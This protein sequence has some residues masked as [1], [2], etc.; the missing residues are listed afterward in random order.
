MSHRLISRNP[1]LKQLRDEGYEI[2]ITGGYVVVHVPYVDS[3]P[4]VQQ[5]ALAFPYTEAGG[6]VDKPRDH[7]CFWVGKPP[8]QRDGAVMLGIKAGDSHSEIRPGMVA[9]MQLSTKPR[10]EPGAT[11]TEPNFYVKFKRY[12]QIITPAAE[13]LD[14]TVKAASH[15]AVA[16]TD[17][18]S[19]FQYTDT[20][21]SRAGINA[22]AAKFKPLT[23]SIIGLG[24][25]GSYILDLIAKTAVQEIRLFD[26]D[27]FST[28]NAFRAPGAA[29][30][31]DLD[32]RQS[33]VAYFAAMYSK[34]Y[35]HVKPHEVR[36]DASN[37]QLLD[38]TS[39][40]FVC[41]DHGDARRAI[42]EQLQQRAIPFAD[43]GMGVQ[44]L[45]AEN[46]LF[47]TVRVTT[48]S[49]AKSDHLLNGRRVSL[50]PPK[51]DDAYKQNIQIADLNAL[52]AV[53]AVLRWK[54]LFG[55]Y[56]DAEHEHHS[57]YTVALN[58][59]T[60]YEHPDGA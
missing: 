1:D 8:C 54:K 26:D 16:T 17:D 29:S 44:Y 36:I 20:A 7:T 51:E 23:I 13:S 43:V 3:A 53:L 24:G 31:E 59:L 10:V 47:G 38:G 2:E 9:T 33:K 34:I 40:A 22:I 12:I 45:A 30:I 50:A 11:Y 58:L 15:R 32:K 37:A 5:G 6:I 19:P 57:T 21:S 28:H 27:G 56:R 35:K 14:A 49:S 55:I 60:S 52:N 39:F 4:S 41:V 46:V 25:T 48:S 42:I 18:D